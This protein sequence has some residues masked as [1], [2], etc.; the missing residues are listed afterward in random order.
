MPKGEPLGDALHPENL[1]PGEIEILE[2]EFLG[3]RIKAF[4]QLTSGDRAKI[5][6][7]LEF[8]KDDRRRAWNFAV[9]EE[10]AKAKFAVAYGALT[11]P[12]KYP[13]FNPN[14]VQ[15][16]P[17]AAERP[18]SPFVGKPWASVWAPEIKGTVSDRDYM[19]RQARRA[20]DLGGGT[21]DVDKAMSLFASSG[22]EAAMDYV[23]N[24]YAQNKARDH[25]AG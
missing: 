1:F 24:S 22:V 3:P 13:K 7:W 23:W 19:W 20:H 2:A 15:L 14:V 18:P 6:N 17:V 21:C 8:P 11:Q 10:W 9:G 4:W 12:G 16:R 5:L 25:A